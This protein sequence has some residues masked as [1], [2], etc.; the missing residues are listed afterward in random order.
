MEV[1]KRV[2]ITINLDFDG[3]V[4]SHEFPKVGNDIG[5]VPVLKR[6]VNAGHQ[7][8]LFTM[9]SDKK[10]RK[11]SSDPNIID[12]DGQF[13]TEA[14]EWFKENDIPLWGIQ[15]NP[16]Q[17]IWTDSPK[18]YAELMIDDTGLNIPLKHDLSISKRPFVDWNAV[19]VWL[20]DK[21][22]I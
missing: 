6:L 5:S 12:V 11:P 14:I 22:I 10:D 9:R 2:G 8:I 21:G 3:T 19:E 18:S 4:V 1:Q 17:K 7:L 13:L 20:E 15:T 16:D